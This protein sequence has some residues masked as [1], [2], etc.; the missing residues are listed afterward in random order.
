MSHLMNRIKL[1]KEV[2]RRIV[3]RKGRERRMGIEE[4]KKHQEEKKRKE[5]ERNSKRTIYKYSKKEHIYFFL[6]K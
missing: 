5:G 2:T 4:R 3:M 6:L 1:G